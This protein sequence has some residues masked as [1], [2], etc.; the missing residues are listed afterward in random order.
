[1]QVY[2]NRA[3]RCQKI[4][5][6]CFSCLFIFLWFLSCV[7]MIFSLFTVLHS[8]LF[9]VLFLWVVWVCSWFWIEWSFWVLL[10]GNREKLSVSCS[11]C[12]WCS[13]SVDL[14]RCC[15]VVLWFIWFGV[16]AFVMMARLT[17]V[18]ATPQ[19][20]TFSCPHKPELTCQGQTDECVCVLSAYGHINSTKKRILDLFH[21]VFTLTE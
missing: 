5:H 15:A 13:L 4:K 18:Q 21:G 3:V 20:F 7:A 17:R 10:P 14:C 11:V 2:T 6:F 16:L 8:D 1:M 12:E 9:S 19:D